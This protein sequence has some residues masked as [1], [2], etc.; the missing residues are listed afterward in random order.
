MT[1]DDDENIITDINNGK[2]PRRGEDYNKKKPILFC[3]NGRGFRSKDLV[4]EKMLKSIKVW[5]GQ[6]F[7]DKIIKI[8][9]CAGRLLST[10]QNEI[11]NH[12][13]ID[14]VYIEKAKYES[15]SNNFI[16]E[17][18]LSILEQFGYSGNMLKI[19]FADEKRAD[20]VDISCLEPIYWGETG[21]EY[22][23]DFNDPKGVVHSYLKMPDI[24][25]LYDKIPESSLGYQEMIVIDLKDGEILEKHMQQQRQGELRIN[26]PFFKKHSI[27]QVGKQLRI[28]CG[29]LYAKRRN[30]IV[31]ID[32]QK[33]LSESEK[34]EVATTKINDEAMNINEVLKQEKIDKE[35]G[36]KMD[37]KEEV[38]SEDIKE[39]QRLREIVGQDTF[40]NIVSSVC[41]IAKQ[42]IDN[43]ERNA[44]ISRIAEDQRIKDD[45]E[46]TRL[47]EK[48]KERKADIDK[49]LENLSADAKKAVKYGTL[50]LE[51][52]PGTS[53]TYDA[54]KV[55][56]E[57]ENAYIV[58]KEKDLTFEELKDMG[59]VDRIELDSSWSSSDLMGGMTYHT[60]EEDKVAD[61]IKPVSKS[62]ILT[63]MNKRNI[64]S[65]LG[66]CTEEI[67]SSTNSKI[68]DTHKERVKDKNIYKYISRHILL[69]EEASR[70]NFESTFGGNMTILES[71][72]RL[73][74]DNQTPVT[75]RSGYSRALAPSMIVICTRNIADKGAKSIDIGIMRRFPRIYRGPDF[76]RIENYIRDDNNKKKLEKGVYECVEH[77]IEALSIINE[78]IGVQ[79]GIDYQIGHTYL[80]V[81]TKDELMSKW[82]DWILPSIL[83]RCNRKFD[84]FSDMLFGEDRPELV[85][86]QKNMP[87]F[88]NMEDLDN[89]IIEIIG[90][91]KDE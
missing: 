47:L 65:A 16:V 10:L 67:E 32:V 19:L 43:D 1:N 15:A 91:G 41:D 51:G 38:V 81:K 13:L 52:P 26:K 85:G 66:L 87:K 21:K 37:Q 23:W 17:L 24:N 45:E 5:K 48:E 33:L 84:M 3:F 8:E 75:N 82:T 11:F 80:Y 14:G 42:K 56:C 83:D 53:K 4:I 77:S 22:I 70:G 7:D 62:G 79:L 72:R 35:E 88:E 57:I 58:D 59:L 49:N 27:G 55:V 28:R 64:G 18:C 63:K 46:K 39:L 89:F 12:K 78:R 73:G 25:D 76:K 40:V 74:E 69:V 20:R 61:S 90:S 54:E 71:E 86:K 44:D 30:H 50:F 68:L 36:T 31:I 6:L 2:Y 9:T 60:E 34:I 29:F